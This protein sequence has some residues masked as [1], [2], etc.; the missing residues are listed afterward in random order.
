VRTAAQQITK[1][2]LADGQVDLKSTEI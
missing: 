1:G 2:G